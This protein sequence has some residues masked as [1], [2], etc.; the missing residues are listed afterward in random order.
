MSYPSSME[1]HPREIRS[2][3]LLLAALA[4]CK[5]LHEKLIEALHES[6]AA[7]CGQKRVRFLSL[8]HGLI[9]P[10]TKRGGQEM[11]GYVVEGIFKRRWLEKV[12]NEI[13]AV[14]VV[15]FDWSA[16]LQPSPAE[17]S[18]AISHLQHIRRQAH[19]REI[20]L[21][22]F[23]LCILTATNLKLSAAL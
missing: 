9:V 20:R 16:V 14:I 13:P 21:L 17:E 4:G 1:E 12:C 2:S 22:V 8:D 15:V 7:A 5:H 10:A 6:A 23:L 3:P 18:Q 11:P 19:S